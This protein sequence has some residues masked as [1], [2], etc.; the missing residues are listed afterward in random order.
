VAFLTEDGLLPMTTTH[1]FD[2]TRERSKLFTH[3]TISAVA[4]VLGVGAYLY[5][6]TLG[7]NYSRERDN[8]GNTY[9]MYWTPFST[10]ETTLE[11]EGNVQSCPY[12]T[13]AGQRPNN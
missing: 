2:T 7:V 4:A 5:S 3:L 1:L 8:I 10:F 11:D 9:C 12:F 6:T 13:K